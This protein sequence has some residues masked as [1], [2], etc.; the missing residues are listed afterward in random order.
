MELE[1]WVIKKANLESL[2]RTERMMVRSMDV[3]SVAE[4]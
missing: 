2:E 4:W 1:I 3:R